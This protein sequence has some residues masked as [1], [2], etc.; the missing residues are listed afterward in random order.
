[1]KTAVRKTAKTA[2]RKS[3]DA[4]P[5]DVMFGVWD[6]FGGPQNSAERQAA[7]FVVSHLEKLYSQRPKELSEASD[8]A[9]FYGVQGFSLWLTSNFL[10]YANQLA[11]E[12]LSANPRHAAKSK[13]KKVVA[14]I[15]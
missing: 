13:I 9:F 5:P 11:E 1:M 4:I 6:A 8:R 15:G 12:A 14:P 10:D 3:P 2:T 7:N